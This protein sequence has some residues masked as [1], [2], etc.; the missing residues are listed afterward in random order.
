M[1]F[2]VPGL[3]QG[4]FE[5]AVGHGGAAGDPPVPGHPLTCFP[6]QESLFVVL[7]YLPPGVIALVNFLGP[8]LFVSLIQLENYPPNTEVNLALVW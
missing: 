8:L 5:G 6:L 1:G 3:H 2:L 7:Q 4:T